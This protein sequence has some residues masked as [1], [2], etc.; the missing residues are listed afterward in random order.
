MESA[1]WPIFGIHSMLNIIN[2]DIIIGDIASMPWNFLS[3]LYRFFSGHSNLFLAFCLSTSFALLLMLHMFLEV[4]S[5]IF[6]ISL[7]SC[8]QWPNG[9]KFSSSIKSISGWML[10][11]SSLIST[12]Q[13]SICYISEKLT[14]FQKVIT[15]TKKRYKDLNMNKI[16]FA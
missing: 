11:A 16:S 8:I 2:L 6:T 14:W 15:I 5:I 4:K 9:K 1:L 13:L 12:S 10:S 3:G 7:V